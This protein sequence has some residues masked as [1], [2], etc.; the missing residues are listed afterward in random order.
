MSMPIGV[1][2]I[3]EHVTAA[4]SMPPS[5]STIEVGFATTY[6]S[7][8]FLTNCV[9]AQVYIEVRFYEVIT[10]FNAVPKRD[11]MRPFYL[12]AHR[13]FAS[14]NFN[15]PSFEVVKVHLIQDVE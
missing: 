13:L 7:E 9:F 6:S 11:R 15:S 2:E 12:E 5:S 14:E 4:G 8:S 3:S 1:V 10:D